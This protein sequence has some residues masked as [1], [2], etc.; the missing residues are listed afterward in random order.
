MVPHVG[1]RN[2]RKF[3]T[4]EY[5]HKFTEKPQREIS[6]RGADLEMKACFTAITHRQA[7]IIRRQRG[8]RLQS[9]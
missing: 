9:M 3:G 5:G 6:A 7:Q 8:N 1:Y 4:K 2:L